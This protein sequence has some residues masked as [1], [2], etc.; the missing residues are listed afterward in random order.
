MPG[1][2]MRLRR[3]PRSE[4]PYD[5]EVDWRDAV[6]PGQLMLD[7]SPAAVAAAGVPSEGPAATT[8]NGRAGNGLIR[9]TGAVDTVGTIDAVSTRARAL[10]HGRPVVAGASTDARAAVHRFVRHCVEVL[11]GYRPATHLRQLA[12]PAEAATIVA[13]GTAGARRVAGLRKAAPGRRAA[14]RPS[15]V[16]VIS[17]H[18]CQPSPAAVEAAVA[19]VTGQRTWALALRLELHQE[20]WSATA[21]RLI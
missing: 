14:R 4:P 16:A 19:L 12:R 7:W 10:A 2:T 8:G 20:T 18:L 5:D 1:T 9:V 11:N 17:L 15:P 6:I 21:L 3:V 13:Q